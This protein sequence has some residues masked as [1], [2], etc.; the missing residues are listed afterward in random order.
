M[1]GLK[2]QIQCSGKTPCSTCVTEACRCIFDPNSDRRR[3]AHV[4]EL[5]KSHV[6][7]CRVTAKLR[8]DTVDEVIAFILDIQRL[9]TDQEAVEYLVQAL[10]EQ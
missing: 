2:F 3:K 4:A 7:L 10:R 5:M 8:S 1:L 6:T 9:S